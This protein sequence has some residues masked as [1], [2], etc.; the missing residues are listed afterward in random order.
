[1]SDIENIPEPGYYGKLPTYG[2]FITKRLPRDFIA[3]WDEWLQVGIAAAKERLPQEWLTFY[4]NCPPWKFVLG[5]GI[6]GEQPCA[7]VTIPSVD[8]VGRYFNFTLAT[9]LPLYTVPSQFLIR[10]FDWLEGLED[11]AL[12]AL[13]EELDQDAIESSIADFGVLPV[14]GKSAR[15]VYDSDDEFMRLTFHENAE[16]QEQ[17][18]ALLHELLLPS[19]GEDHGFWLQ[20]GSAQVNAQII[21]TSGMPSKGLFLDMLMKEDAQD[22]VEVPDEGAEDDDIL[23]QFLSS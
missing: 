10:H 14:T 11:L 20:R 13:D 12:K 6:C 1:M 19:R 15:P 16:T 21:C 23:E 22:P 3:P 7:G 9:M 8:K 5:S 18:Q 4:L 17:V 2:D